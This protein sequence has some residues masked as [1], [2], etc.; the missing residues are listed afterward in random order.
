MDIRDP[1]TTYS[2]ADFA[3][4]ASRLIEEIRERGNLPVL[5]GGTMLYFRALQRGLSDLPQAHP[6]VRARLEALP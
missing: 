6:E 3:I 4:D 5:V 2:A 1:L